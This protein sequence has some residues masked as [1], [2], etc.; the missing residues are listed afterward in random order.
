M[1]LSGDR[2]FGAEAEPHLLKYVVNPASYVSPTEL[3]SHF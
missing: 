3:P 1:A 2:V